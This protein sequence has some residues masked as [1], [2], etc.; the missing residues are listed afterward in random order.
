MPNPIEPSMDPT[1]G[2]VGKVEAAKDAA[3]IAPQPQPVAPAPEQA[4]QPAQQAGPEPY[5]HQSY[6]SMI[7]PNILQNDTKRTPTP[8]EQ[9]SNARIFWNVIAQRTNNDFVK[10]I[11]ERLADQGDG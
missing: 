4:A 6:M 8:F 9:Q 7:P 10:F 11:Y 2:E 5:R 3:P 1:Q